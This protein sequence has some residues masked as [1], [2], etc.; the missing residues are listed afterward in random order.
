[1]WRTNPWFCN[2]S[3]KQPIGRSSIDRLC[4]SCEKVWAEFHQSPMLPTS[5][6]Y[7]SDGDAWMF[8]VVLTV[9]PSAAESITSA[10]AIAGESASRSEIVAITFNTQ[11][12]IEVVIWLSI[13]ETLQAGSFYTTDPVGTSRRHQNLHLVNIAREFDCFGW[14]EVGV[15]KRKKLCGNP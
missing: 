8:T 7:T 4:A 14:P 12:L 2:F 5:H 9:N 13:P 1:M 3:Q 15:I 11:S 6:R 10:R